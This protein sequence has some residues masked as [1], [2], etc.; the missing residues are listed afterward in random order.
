MNLIGT[1]TELEEIVAHLKSEFE[2][3]DLGKTRY[4]LNLKIEYC[5]DG[6]LV[7]QLNYTQKVLR[8]FN[9]DK[10]KPSSTPIVVRTLDVK[11][12]PFHP[13]EDDEEIFELKVPY[14][15][16]IGALLYLAQC[17]RPDISFAVNLLARYINALTR[18]HWNGVKDIFCYLKGTTDLGLFYTHKS[19]RV[20]TP[21]GPQIDYRLVGYADAG[22]LS[23]PYRARSQTGYVFTIEDTTISWRSTKQTLVTTSSNH[24]EILTLNKASR[25]CFC[26]REVMVHIRSTRGLTSVVDFPMTIFEDKAACI[27]QLKKRYIKGDNTKHIAPKF[28]YSHQQ[29]QHQNIEV[30]QI[31]S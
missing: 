2:M 26:P 8:N 7:H 27:E 12:D 17:T 3:K 28:F 18:R 22:Y 5:S 20:A 25:E 10:T 30:K 13:N 1:S 11:R 23:D 16:A 4:C 31:R 19:S 9:E 29:Q 21:Y 15:S 14:V 24:A 6:I